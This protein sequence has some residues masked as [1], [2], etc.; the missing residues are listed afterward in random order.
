MTLGCVRPRL[1]SVLFAPLWSFLC[2]A[3]CERKSEASQHPESINRISLKPLR[4]CYAFSLAVE[5]TYPVPL[6]AVLATEIRLFAEFLAGGTLE[7]SGVVIAVGA[8]TFALCFGCDF[9]GWRLIHF[10]RI[11]SVLQLG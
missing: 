3:C 7:T 2:S 5:L 1:E 9:F 8:F 11:D 6:E 4:F 10:D